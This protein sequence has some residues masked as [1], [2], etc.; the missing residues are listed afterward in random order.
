MVVVVQFGDRF[1]FWNG[2]AEERDDVFGDYASEL[3]KGVICFRL[4]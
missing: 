4:N 1:I 3:G 2:G